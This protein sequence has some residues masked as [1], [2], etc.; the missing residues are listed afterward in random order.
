MDITDA[1]GL[2]RLTPGLIENRLTGEVR[3]MDKRDTSCITGMSYD[4]FLRKCQAAFD[5]GVWPKTHWS[6]GRVTD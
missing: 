5:T 2:W 4:K 3:K 1:G 6:S